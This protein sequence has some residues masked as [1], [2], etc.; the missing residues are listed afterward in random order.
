MI[1]STNP[2]DLIKFFKFYNK[3][4][5]RKPLVIVPSSFSH[6]TEKKINDLGANIIIYANHLL[7]SAYP[8]ILKTAHSIL[9]YSRA[10]EAEN[11]C[12]QLKKYLI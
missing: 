11:Q 3:F 6:M 8:N 1:H 5:N 2:N 10:K 12:Y 7:R 9:K 4:K